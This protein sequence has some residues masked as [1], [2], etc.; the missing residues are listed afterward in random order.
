MTDGLKAM[1]QH[2]GLKLGSFVIEYATPGIGHT[3]RNAGCEFAMLDMEHSGFGYETIKAA[4]GWFA[5]AGL[6][7]IVRPPSQE[8]HHVARAADMGAEGI[9]VPMVGA[10][11]QAARFVAAARYTPDGR[12]GV[13]LGIAHD[14]YG[15]GPPQ[16]TMAAANRRMTCVALIETAEGVEHADAIAGTPGVDLVWIGHYDLSASLGVPGRFDSRAFQDAEAAIV[17]ACRRHGRSLGRMAASPAD[18]VALFERGH[19]FICYAGD[20]W[21]L[22][23]AVRQ[24]LDAIRAGC[25]GAAAR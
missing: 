2:R 15:S 6:P 19:D 4:L 17:G 24:G 25:A 8:A 23:Q 10:G 22:Q 5:A 11:E 18:G 7:V 21:L 16:E 3:L 1:T 12:R 9:M 14:R 13:A 20:V